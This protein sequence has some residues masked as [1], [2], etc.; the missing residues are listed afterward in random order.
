MPNSSNTARLVRQALPQFRTLQ[1]LSKVGIHPP[2]YDSNALREFTCHF[3]PSLSPVP[4]HPSF[5]PFPAWPARYS[6]P[7]WA[8]WSALPEAAF[9]ALRRGLHSMPR[10]IVRTRASRPSGAASDCRLHFPSLRRYRIRA[11]QTAPHRTHAVSAALH[12]PVGRKRLPM[13]PM[14]LATET[15]A[16]L[17]NHSLAIPAFRAPPH[18]SQAPLLSHAALPASICPLAGRSDWAFDLMAEPPTAAAET[19]P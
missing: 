1:S 15:V 8:P 18:R 10:S 16:Y 9:P 13:A 3:R 11:L 7:L 6:P 17:P 19:A 2:F 5:H 12:S 14:R 4:P